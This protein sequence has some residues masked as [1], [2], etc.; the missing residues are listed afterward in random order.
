MPLDPVRE[1]YS[2]RLMKACLW[3][4]EP[5]LVAEAC[6]SRLDVTTTSNLW[7]WSERSRSTEATLLTE[8]H[9]LLLL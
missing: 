3:L 5:E 2:S 6:W 1:H 4:V 7:L 8:A 9:W